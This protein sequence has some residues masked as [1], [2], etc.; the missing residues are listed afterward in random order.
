MLS[1][2][3][4]GKILFSIRAEPDS[5]L[6]SGGIRKMYEWIQKWKK[7]PEIMREVDDFLKRCSKTAFLYF[8]GGRPMTQA[9]FE[10]CLEEMIQLEKLRLYDSFSSS[11]PD[12]MEI[13]DRQAEELEEKG[14]REGLPEEVKKQMWDRIM[15]NIEGDRKNS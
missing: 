7:E 3:F 11:H 2:L 14:R 4:C 8:T 10:L 13:F 6:K 5:W 1:E 12:M 9:G 15:R